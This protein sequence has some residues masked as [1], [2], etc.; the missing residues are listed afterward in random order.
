MHNYTGPV[1]VEGLSLS[2]QNTT[3]QQPCLLIN[4]VASIR[5]NVVGLPRPEI[6][7][8]RNNAQVNPGEPPFERYSM[9]YFDEVNHPPQISNMN[10][11]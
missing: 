7:F 4:S 8:F 9:P 3:T 2:I 6:T 5:C 1:S 11:S 10:N